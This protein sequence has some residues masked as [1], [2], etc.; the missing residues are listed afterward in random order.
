MQLCDDCG[1]VDARTTLRPSGA[2]PWARGSRTGSWVRLQGARGLQ[3][4]GR[5]PGGIGG[6]PLPI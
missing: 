6:T 2:G 5:P 3:G 1:F 4:G